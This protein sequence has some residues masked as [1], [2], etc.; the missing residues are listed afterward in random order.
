MVSKS[1]KNVIPKGSFVQYF[2][3]GPFQIQT[4]S[5][6]VMLFYSNTLNIL[7]I[8]VFLNCGS[9]K[10]QN[11]SYLDVSGTLDKTLGIS[12]TWF[13]FANSGSLGMSSIG[14]FRTSG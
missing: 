1:N 9:F 8:L 4:A 14:N 13:G 3:I 6:I 5:K 10:L 2:V 11:I 12:G 7:C